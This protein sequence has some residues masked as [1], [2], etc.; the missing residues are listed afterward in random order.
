MRGKDV[1]VIALRILG[2][3]AIVNSLA[4]LS[5]PLSALGWIS[6]K[7][8]EFPEWPGVLVSSILPFAVLLAA[9]LFLILKA[10]RVARWLKLDRISPAGD[11]PPAL[12]STVLQAVAFS[13]VGVVLVSQAIP[14]SFTTLSAF[15]IEAMRTGRTLG[16][17]LG[18]LAKLVLGMCLFF[19]GGV[20]ARFWHA[21]WRK[22]R[23]RD[24]TEPGGGP[25]SGSG[26]TGG[27]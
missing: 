23:S 2:L 16:R 24:L 4:Q 5:G 20:L 17:L 27:I 15:S 25:A 11:Q 3:Y 8:A 18:N 22:A 19:G 6:D 13:V 21:A 26:P 7:D 14:Q 10:D 12:D 1:G 9:G